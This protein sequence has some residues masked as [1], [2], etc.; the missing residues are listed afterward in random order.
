[1][2]YCMV[3]F[4]KMS[5]KVNRFL[6]HSGTIDVIGRTVTTSERT[7]SSGC[8]KSTEKI[9]VIEVSGHVSCSETATVTAATTYTNC[10]N[11]ILQDDWLLFSLIYGL[12]GCF[13]SK[14]PDLT[15]HIT[16]ICNRAGQMGQL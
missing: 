9:L 5:V 3:V 11:K 16:N 15:C 1:M 2:H 8:T 7:N 10:V 12:F 4:F 13:R 14:L 6:N